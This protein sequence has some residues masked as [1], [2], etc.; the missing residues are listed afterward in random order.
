MRM[1]GSEFGISC[2][3]IN[4]RYAYLQA[5]SYILS[6]PSGDGGGG[7]VL[8]ISDG[9]ALALLLTLRRAAWAAGGGGASYCK[10]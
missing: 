4:W 1:L 9:A 6:S 10:R 8:D 2:I 3:Y 7:T 5:L